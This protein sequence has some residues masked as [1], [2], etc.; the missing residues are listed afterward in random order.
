MVF[1]DF[2]P[3]HGRESRC[4]VRYRSGS[5]APYRFQIY[6]SRA[7][8]LSLP[9]STIGR[10]WWARTAHKWL[11]VTPHSHQPE[12]HR[13]SGQLAHR[14][15]NSLCVPIELS[16]EEPHTIAVAMPRLPDMSEPG[17][18]VGADSPSNVGFWDRPPISLSVQCRGPLFGSSVTSNAKKRSKSAVFR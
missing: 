3:P 2:P 9:S 13:G 16:V 17:I 10:S 5:L 12:E 15:A 7:T 8:C 11:G 18:D 4:H 14:P 1:D 6:F